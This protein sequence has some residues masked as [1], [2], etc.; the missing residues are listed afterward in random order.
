MIFFIDLM[1][2]IFDHVF[3]GYFQGIAVFD[4]IVID[5]SEVSQL[6]P[7]IIPLIFR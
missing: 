1:A 3:F 7:Y 4:G 2:F 5:I 6:F